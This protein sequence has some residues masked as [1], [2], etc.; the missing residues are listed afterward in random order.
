MAWLG[1]WENRAKIYIKATHLTESSVN[2]PLLLKIPNFVKESLDYDV[3]NIKKIA[4]TTED[5]LTQ[6]HTSPDYI[7]STREYNSTKLDI[8]DWTQ[9]VLIPLMP[10]TS[11]ISVSNTKWIY[12]YYDKTQNDNPFA[13]Y[14]HSSKRKG[15]IRSP[16]LSKIFSKDINGCI[17]KLS[18]DNYNT[19][20]GQPKTF[21]PYLTD[22]TDTYQDSGIYVIGERYTTPTALVTGLNGVGLASPPSSYTNVTFD[23]IVM[24]LY[25]YNSFT[26]SGWVYGNNN[27]VLFSESIG[28]TNF[29]FQIASTSTGVNV[30][31]IDREGNTEFNKTIDIKLR[32]NQWNYIVWHEYPHTFSWWKP[33]DEVNEYG[34]RPNTYVTT[35]QFG[36]LFVNSDF[37]PYIYFNRPEIGT[38]STLVYIGKGKAPNDT[39][40][41]IENYRGPHDEWTIYSESKGYAWHRNDYLQHVPDPNSSQNMEV[42][43][44]EPIPDPPVRPDPPEPPVIPDPATTTTTTT[45]S[46]PVPPVPPT[47]TTTTTTTSST[48]PGPSAPTTPTTTTTTTTTRTP[49]QKVIQKVETVEIRKDIHYTEQDGSDSKSTINT[50]N[51]ESLDLGPVPPGGTSDTKILYLRVPKGISIN[52]IKIALIDTGGII[53]GD[54]VFG[55]ETR[56]YLDYNI[57]PTNYFEGINEDQS[58]T[59]E[60]NVDIPNNGLLESQYIYVNVTLPEDHLFGAGTVRYKWIFDYQSGIMAT[61]NTT[62]I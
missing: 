45:S 24:P 27:G 52:N 3:A 61:E 53:F 32:S 19:F 56:N 2:F 20:P 37:G 17:L 30:I 15:T 31:L 44:V 1:N 41:Y 40:T 18:Y 10:G 34:Y 9:W 11:G 12:F 29:L 55:L 36:E 13:H 35:H 49:T 8:T 39:Y 14:D 42:S 22:R 33:D 48:T 21:D 38:S 59:S 16:L 5:G 4:I 25:Q 23:T 6:C 51:S 60:Y 62:S 46:T 26:I 54:T 7:D 50:I 43:W 58:P 57:V 28:G 47:T